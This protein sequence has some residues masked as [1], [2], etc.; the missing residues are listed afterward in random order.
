MSC[1]VTNLSQESLRRLLPSLSVS[2]V[3][4]LHSILPYS[5]FEANRFASLNYS[6]PSSH[7]FKHF[8]LFRLFIFPKVLCAADF[9]TFLSFSSLS[10]NVFRLLL[11]CLNEVLLF[12]CSAILYFRRLQVLF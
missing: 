2:A 12:V 10:H 8:L 7:I 9:I 3:F 4:L 11:N 6:I 5:F 1:A